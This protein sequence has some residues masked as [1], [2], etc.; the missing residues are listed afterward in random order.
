MPKPNLWRAITLLYIGGMLYVAIEYIWRGYSHPS[1]FVVGGLCFLVIGSL[2]EGFLGW[3]MPFWMQAILGAV[4][5]TMVEFVAGYILNIRMGLNVWDY[6]DLPFNFY[7]QICLPYF[8]LWIPLSML[9]ILADDW[10]R[11]ILFGEKA[12]VYYWRITS[13]SKKS[14][15][16]P[17]ISTSGIEPEGI[18]PDTWT[19]A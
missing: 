6:S 3:N 9:A 8:F 1:M 13:P 10:L 12:P 11:H 15:P 18:A 2:N 7:G 5:V 4:C 14:S 16:A 17:V 19:S